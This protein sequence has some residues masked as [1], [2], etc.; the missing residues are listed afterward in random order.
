MTLL[1]KHEELVCFSQKKSYSY[2]IFIFFAF[3]LLGDTNYQKDH[4][5]NIQHKFGGYDYHHKTV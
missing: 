4:N 2:S 5:E 3:K 1:I